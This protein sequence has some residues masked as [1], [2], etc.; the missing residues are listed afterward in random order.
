MVGLGADGAPCN[1]HLDALSELRLASLL[2]KARRRDA[3]AL[4]PIEAL[5]L[6]TIDGARCLGWDGEI[7]SLEVG[8]RADVTVVSLTGLHHAPAA[9]PLSALVYASSARDV[10]HVLVDGCTRVRSGELLGVDL[11]RL[12]AQSYRR[13]TLVATRAGLTR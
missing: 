1:N 10:R 4:A 9:D 13:A 5:A 12:R 11:A 3:R 6:A 7:G 2:S 8:K